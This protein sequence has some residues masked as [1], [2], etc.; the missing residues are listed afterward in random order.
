MTVKCFMVHQTTRF[1]ASL[2]RF[3]WNSGSQCAGRKDWG[4]D[5]SS[6]PICVIEGIK[7][8]HGC[9]DLDAQERRH[10]PAHDDPRWPVKCEACDYRF[11]EADEWQLFTDHIYVDDAGKEYSGRALPPGAMRFTDY[12]PPEWKGPDGRTLHVI[13]PDG[14]DWSPDHPASNCT[15]KNDRGPFGEAHRCW[16]RHGTAPN[17]T[18]DKNGRT[19]QAG[20]GSIL[21]PKYHGFLRNGAF[22]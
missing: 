9:W 5:A 19:C 6:A 21:T 1:R 10:M 13:C 3:T 20:G 2:R 22:T 18:V 11:V 8:A 12:E 17:I 7:N 15:M 4:H 16:V 14:W